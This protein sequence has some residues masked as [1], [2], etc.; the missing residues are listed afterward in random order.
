MRK[1]KILALLIGVFLMASSITGCGQPVN[2]QESPGS[3]VDADVNEDETDNEEEPEVLEDPPEEIDID[4]DF[5]YIDIGMGG[6]IEITIEELTE[7]LIENEYPDL[8]IEAVVLER[9]AILPGSTVRVSIAITNQGEETI[10]FVVGSGSNEIPE[11]LRMV[12]D[13]LQ[14][15]LS[16]DRLGIATMDFVV[17]TLEPGDTLNYSLYV[18]A[19][20]PHENFNDYTFQ[21][22]TE[23]QS[24]IG[25]LDWETL[26]ERFPNLLEAQPGTYNVSVYFIYSL[27]GDDGEG[28]F[29]EASGFNVATLEIVVD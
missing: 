19:I 25:E 2:I 24:Y 13:E 14:P 4:D 22:F 27:V 7:G 5:E 29:G 12:S 10:A 1:L 20:R 28:M 26:V 21:L 23:D 8:V 18:R 11:A 16:Q 9:M 3:E 6:P 17:E 15:I